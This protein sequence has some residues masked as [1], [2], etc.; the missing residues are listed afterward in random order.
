MTEEK[1][2]LGLDLDGCVA[3]FVAQMRVIY[4]E[5]MG[6]PLADLTPRPSY[7]FPEWGLQNLED[8]NRLHRYAV[9]QREL[10]L[11]MP[12]IAGAIPSLQRLSA[13]GVHI[14]IATHRLFIAYFHEAAASQTIRWL[15]RHGIP[16]W[17]LC[18]IKDKSAVRADLFVEDNGDNI[19]ALDRKRVPVICMNNPTNEGR[20]LPA[21]RVDSWDEAE[22]EI[23]ARYYDWR[24]A[25]GLPLPSGPGL[26]PPGEATR[27]PN[28]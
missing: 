8:Y 21:T 16:Y 4:S 7:G 23:R 5:W 26:A 27:Q 19:E 9:T 14:R 3:D 22:A 2:V 24:R 1:F 10:F 15:E 6:I 12:P 18:L 17:D 13:E 20:D 28:D 25:R 11:A